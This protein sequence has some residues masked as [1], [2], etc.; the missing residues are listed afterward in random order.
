MKLFTALYIRLNRMSLG[1]E[2]TT[3]KDS[4]RKSEKVRH[5]RDVQPCVVL[6]KRLACS[7]RFMLICVAIYRWCGDVFAWWWWWSA[8]VF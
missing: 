1:R 2:D 6:C 3:L 8:I 4:S 7:V 5:D